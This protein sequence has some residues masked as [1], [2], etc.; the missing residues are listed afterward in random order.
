MKV[1]FVFLVC[2]V[3][4]FVNVCLGQDDIYSWPMLGGNLQRNNSAWNSPA[5]QNPNITW[6]FFDPNGVDFFDGLIPIYDHVN[7]IVWTVSSDGFIYQVNANNGSMNYEICVGSAPAFPGDP[8]AGVAFDDYVRGQITMLPTSRDIFMI[9]STP[10]DGP[11]GM[12]RVNWKTGAVEWNI[13]LFNNSENDGSFTFLSQP[14]IVPKALNG[15]TDAIII[16]I[17]SY[18]CSPNPL[19]AQCVNYTIINADTGATV[20]SKLYLS[21][22]YEGFSFVPPMI[23]P[24]DGNIITTY[25][26]DADQKC[27]QEYMC[28]GL[29]KYNTMTG[30]VIWNATT[31]ESWPLGVT[32]SNGILQVST[33][34]LAAYSYYA[35]TGAPVWKIEESVTTFDMF[36]PSICS[37]GTII[38]PDNE[39]YVQGW[40]PEIIRNKQPLFWT[41]CL[42]PARFASTT[43]DGNF[44]INCGNQVSSR[45]CK[46]GDTNWMRDFGP[47]ITTGS[48]AIGYEA[49]YV[50]VYKSGTGGALVKLQDNVSAMDF[51]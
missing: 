44:Y 37:D 24:A 7:E 14:A 19:Q 31:Q 3:S 29:A 8:C 35:K 2:L 39:F 16:W 32:I 45:S 6:A 15:V 23:D 33:S 9:Y 18:D 47:E 20:L 51:W 36:A 1:S 38:F 17:L 21:Y 46:T 34:Q 26:N 4:I 48:V 25:T 43:S 41:G 49:I 5:L 22:S 30:E 50:N 40:T 42:N 13:L 27:N 11:D 12:V 10:Q 28:E